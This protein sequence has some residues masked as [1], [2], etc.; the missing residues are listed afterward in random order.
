MQN[1]EGVH[2]IDHQEIREWAE[3]RGG[4]PAILADTRHSEEGPQLRIDWGEGEEPTEAVSWEEFFRLFDEN[5]L[6]FAYQEDELEGEPNYEYL[7]IPRNEE[8]PLE[9]PAEY[10]GPN[11]FA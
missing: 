9:G 10:Y 11:Y 2:T 5:D 8:E 1:Q 6:A 4:A 7:L 3:S